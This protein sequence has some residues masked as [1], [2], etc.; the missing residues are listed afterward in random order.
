MRRAV[1]KTVSK[2]PT[3]KKEAPAKKKTPAKKERQVRAKTEKATKDY[4]TKASEGM[5]YKLRSGGKERRRP[6]S[7]V[8]R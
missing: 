3:A 8:A 5:E 7:P 6:L 4:P 2:N 1:K